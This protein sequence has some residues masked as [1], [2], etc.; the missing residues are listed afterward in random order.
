M[1]KGDA[2]EI[3]WF[4]DSIRVGD[5]NIVNFELKSGS[6]FRVN[7]WCKEVLRRELPDQS[8]D[9]GYQSLNVRS[10]LQDLHSQ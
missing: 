10:A 3:L 1:S 2:C 6:I 8:V 5:E 9:I 7:K 4:R